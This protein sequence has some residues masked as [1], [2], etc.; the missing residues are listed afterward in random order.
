MTFLDAPPN[1]GH[2]AYDGA[3]RL[4]VEHCVSLPRAMLL[5]ISILPFVVS[6]YPLC[7][8]VMKEKG[9]S[10]WMTMGTGDSDP[11]PWATEDW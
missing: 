8:F 2:H 7:S 5:A 11:S 3:A 9:K 1:R 4:G 10:S 6:D